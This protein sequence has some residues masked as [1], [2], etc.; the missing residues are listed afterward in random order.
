[1]NEGQV[2]EYPITDFIP[3]HPTVDR[4]K[5]PY[6]GDPNPEVRVGVVDSGGGKTRWV[7]IPGV[8]PKDNKNGYYIPVFGWVNKETLY[9][10]VLNRDQNQ[11]DLYFVDVP[12]G[13]S[14]LMLSEKD[15]AWI[16]TNDIFRVLKSGDKFLWLSWRDGHSHLYLYG[17][18]KSNPISAAAVMEKQLTSG[19]FEVVDVDG[20]DEST[21]TL[22]YIS[23]EA[24]DRERQLYSIRLD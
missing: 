22:Y 23:T 4:Q 6:P 15:D 7:N 12:S 9:I 1:M 17:F 2:P 20:V 19:N 14:Q 10:Q 16:K 21:G 24:D 5:Y 11:L 13:R 8:N 18:N 3:D